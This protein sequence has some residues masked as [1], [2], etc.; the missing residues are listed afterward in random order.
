MEMTS[1]LLEE[2]M[3]WPRMQHCGMVLK[4]EMFQL[5]DEVRGIDFSEEKSVEN[6]LE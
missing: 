1:E 4:E 6:D 3:V 2:L 5:W